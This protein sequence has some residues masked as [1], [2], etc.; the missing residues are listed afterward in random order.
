MSVEPTLNDL[1]ISR[2]QSSD[3]Q[4][5]AAIPADQFEAD[6]AD[7]AWCLPALSPA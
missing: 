3:W 6:L 4:R 5:L 2:D 7:A 1:N